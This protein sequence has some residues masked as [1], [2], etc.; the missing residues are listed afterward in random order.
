MHKKQPLGKTGNSGASAFERR[1][2]HNTADFTRAANG[3]PAGRRGRKPRRPEPT[4]AAQEARQTRVVDLHVEGLSAREIAKSL[5][6]DRGTAQ[7]DIRMEGQRRTVE[8]AQ[9]RE[10]AVAESVSRY[11]QVILRATNR[12]AEIDTACQTL[13]GTPAAA[14]EARECDK[15]VLEAQARIDLVLGLTATTPA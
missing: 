3:Q 7:L 13:K 11:E 4:S 10:A 14:R 1:K 15:L 12:L 9:E 2:R 6:I 8:R 5:G